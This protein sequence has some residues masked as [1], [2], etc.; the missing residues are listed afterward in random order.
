LRKPPPE[1]D[2]VAPVER[3]DAV[4]VAAIWAMV[5]AAMVGLV[6]LRF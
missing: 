6:T 5:V 4:I 2:L 3:R 1:L